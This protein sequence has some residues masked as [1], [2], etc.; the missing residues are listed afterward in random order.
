[1]LHAQAKPISGAACQSASLPA[2]ASHCLPPCLRPCLPA[3][4]PAR[5][6]AWAN[7][8][9]PAA[10]S[11]F[12]AAIKPPLCQ[13]ASCTAHCR[14]M[15]T[16]SQAH[17]RKKTKTAVGASATTT[18]VSTWP[19]RCAEMNCWLVEPQPART[20]LAVSSQ[21]QRQG[22]KACQYAR[23]RGSRR[24]LSQETRFWQTAASGHTRWHTVT[25]Q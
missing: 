14:A 22:M 17:P 20:C 2:T 3:L 12:A 9:T 7:L 8:G 6:P 16:C 21:L 11:R 5:P 19:A 13:S 1:M 15:H 23:W 24:V 18:C 10:R 25:A 4:S